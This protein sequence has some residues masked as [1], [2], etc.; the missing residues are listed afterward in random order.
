M[1]PVF[2][3]GWFGF[4]AVH[5]LTRSVRDSAALLDATRGP[6][7]GDPYAAPPV[8]RPFADEVGAHPGRLRVGVVTGGILAPVED[9][10][11]RTAV[12]EAAG[13]LEDLGHQVEGIELPLIRDELVE[14][15]VALAAAEVA[16][17]I[18]MSAVAVGRDE[19]DPDSYEP[20]T[21][22]LGMV[23]RALPAE[24]VSH[25]LFVA[26][27]AGRAIGRLMEGYDVLLSSTMA[28]PPWP[29][30]ELDPSPGEER[31][32]TVLRRAPLKPAL[33]AAVERLAP[34]VLAP[35]PNT[36]IFNMTGQPAMSVPLHWTES[37]LPVGV[38]LAG[39]YGD[40][41]TLFRLAAQLEEARPWFDRRPPSF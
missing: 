17:G 24:A 1:G 41:A 9:R 7:P 35:I 14:A 25:A 16:H 2:G 37:G 39:R 38:Q 3:E 12:S 27:R 22:V 26:R 20:T 29:H 13:L 4:S 34:R 31:L 11:V 23:G 30:H 15:F 19:P 32:V 28:R 21:W 6:E 8:E 18:R 10:E 40:E 5:A 33:M 36:P